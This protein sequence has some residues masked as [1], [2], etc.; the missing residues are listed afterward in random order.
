[1]KRIILALT[2][3]LSLGACAQWNNLVTA[4]QLGT[5]SIANPITK[6]RLNQ[7]EAA[8]TL[9]FAGLEAWK[10]SCAQGLLNAD[11]KS[12]VATVQV[13]TRQ[14]PPYLTQLREFVRNNDQVNATV[15][16]NQITS[17][18]G[19]IKSQAATSGVNLGG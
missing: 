1:M 5:A 7:T 19:T 2:L 11:C 16:F 14:I 13:Y 9:V 10:K 12:Q 17:L 3:A 6:D 8:I 4:V 15:A 18:V